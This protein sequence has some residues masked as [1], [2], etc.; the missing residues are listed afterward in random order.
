MCVYKQSSDASLA[1]AALK[2]ARRLSKRADESGLLSAWTDNRLVHFAHAGR[3][4]AS[5]A[6]RD[7]KAWQAAGEHPA[8]SDV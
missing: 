4:F 3:R 1:C 2:D 6:P 8:L 7:W 5:V